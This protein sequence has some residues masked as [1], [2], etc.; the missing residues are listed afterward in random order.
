MFGYESQK[1]QMDLFKDNPMT[2]DTPKGKEFSVYIDTPAEF[3]GILIGKLVRW[4]HLDMVRFFYTKL[5]GTSYCM[6]FNSEDHFR[7][8]TDRYFVN[9][10]FASKHYLRLRFTPK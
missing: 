10:G 2:V 8:W 7:Q 4:N 3:G 9:A 6:D 5:D 1:S